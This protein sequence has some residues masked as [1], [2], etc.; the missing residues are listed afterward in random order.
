MSNDQLVFVEL[1]DALVDCTPNEQG[2]ESRFNCLREYVPDA[3][4]EDLAKRLMATYEIEV[5]I[6]DGPE[7]G[8]LLKSLHL[9]KRH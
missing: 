8:L 1:N 2:E 5:S 9:A 7:A 4:F 3:F 6:V